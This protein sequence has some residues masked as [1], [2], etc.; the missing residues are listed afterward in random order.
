MKYGLLGP[1][2]LKTYFFALDLLF[3]YCYYLSLW[4]EYVICFEVESCQ[5]IELVNFQT[6]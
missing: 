2:A 4:T 5:E 6:K 3:K 1:V